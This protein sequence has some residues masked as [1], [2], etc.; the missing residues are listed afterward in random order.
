MS[1]LLPLGHPTRIHLG[2]GL[3]AALLPSFLVLLLA[4]APA[5]AQHYVTRTYTEQQGLPS[6]TVYGVSQDELGRIWFLTRAGLTTY[7]GSAW[8]MP[9]A[10]AEA[11]RWQYLELAL[12]RRGDAWLAAGFPSFSLIRLHDG[13]AIPVP[14]PDDPPAPSGFG[15][16]TLRLAVI[17]EAAGPRVVVSSREHGL[18]RW[19]GR[20]WHRFTRKEG[21]PGDHVT[22]LAAQ[23]RRCL[24]GTESG[25]A[26]LVGD[27]IVPRPEL[28][29]DAPSRHV[30]ALATE[31]A[32]GGPRTWV[33]GPDWVGWIHDGAFEL[34]GR[35]L[36]IALETPED[37]PVAEPDGAG[38]LYFGGA[39]GLYHLDGRT[40]EVESL[41]RDNGLVGDGA[42]GLLLDREGNLWVTT[43]RG[44]SKVAHRE[45][46]SW[47]ASQGLFDDEVT[48]ILPAAGESDGGATDSMVLGHQHGLTFFHHGPVRTVDLSRP[49]LPEMRT[50]RVFDLERAAGGLWIAA[51]R[52]GLARIG[53]GGRVRWFDRTVAPQVSVTAV[54]RDASGRLWVGTDEG[55]A[56]ID[57]P[58]AV[59]RGAAPS[60]R[61]VRDGPLAGVGVRR[62]QRGGDGT[63]YFGTF[64]HG[65][66]AL[67]DGTWRQWTS[68]EPSPANDTYAAA[69]RGDRLW[70]GTGAGLLEA[71]GDGHLE[72]PAEP[73]LRIERPVY[74]LLT[75]AEGRLWIGTDYGLFRW[76]GA[77]RVHF[78]G[79]D[80][81]AGNELNRAAGV[82]DE[83]GRVWVGTDRGLT[84]FD[85]RLEPRR[86]PP[87]PRPRLLAVEVDGVPSPL[88]E[89]A[90][91]PIRVG[92]RERN[93]LFRVS[94]PSFVDED[95]VHYRT[96]LEGL[97]DGWTE[98]TG[99]TRWES[100]YRSLPSGT[101]RFLVE[102]RSDASDWS[103]TVRSPRVRVVPPVW[104]RWWFLVLVLGVVA[105]VAY[106]I[107]RELGQRRYARTLE[108]EVERR[109]AALVRSQKLESLGVLAGGIA[110]DFNNILT[111]ILGYLS[112][113]RTSP[114]LSPGD[115]EQLGRAEHALGRA[116]EL[117]ARLL[118]FARGGAPVTGPVAVGELVRESC[119]FAAR[120]SNVVFHFDLPRDLWS[121]EADAGQLS[122]VLSNLTLNA[123]QAMP[124]GGTVSVQAEN[125]DLRPG[126][127]AELEPELA[128]G[129]YVHLVVE[130]DGPGIEAAD[131]PRIFDPF[132]TTKQHGSG[133]GLATAYSIVKS[134]GGAMSV[135]SE[136]GAGTR[137][138]LYLPAS[139]AAPRVVRPDAGAT[140][141][142]GAGRVLVMDDEAP[143]RSVLGAMLGR[144]GYDVEVAERGEEAVERWRQAR[145]EGRPFDLTILDLTVPGG[146]G[147]VETME[148]LRALDPEVVGVATS[149]YAHDPVLSSPE[150]YGF[151]AVLPKPF[152]LATLSDVLRKLRP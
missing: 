41:G 69:R 32:T 152:Q 80:G 66:V 11:R 108:Q 132:F 96:R 138:D 110:H 65:T 61:P 70:I 67:R 22:A 57:D 78:T 123:V 143:V 109:S 124:A 38:G 30:L 18:W 116:E 62:I 87:P 91:K 33:V 151:R 42:T 58:G 147:G 13:R 9:L 150:A 59:A 142:P 4:P 17:Q 128:P 25:L 6:S 44:V 145:A 90:R 148:C 29:A 84:R 72:R 53:P 21:L 37:L 8:S 43:L 47:N 23:G 19:D 99:G 51:A 104:R 146:M 117:T 52:H 134:H 120:G 100:R 137:F 28:L 112:L 82:V 111:V 7:D 130:D 76:D 24:V 133:L 54:R 34:A 56:V 115:A 122:Q 64:G 31:P 27:R 113:V 74:L 5:R 3:A 93:V 48:A 125:A 50:G 77:H 14:P 39:V 136:P 68:D 139:S 75:D 140:V 141:R 73:E 114:D 20:S 83:R 94:A 16:R 107:S 118:T 79:A 12:D 2:F 95:R 85:V 49:E 131:L 86:P 10:G 105:A 55:V 98:T 88:G 89:E 149:G 1:S 81:L 26:E 144:L 71:T 35:A 135:E 40:G 127:V 121:I 60:V 106:G 103:A 126:R 36:D 97:D 63:L 102:A 45:I 101:Y 15:I 119:E 92:P 129:R 46:V